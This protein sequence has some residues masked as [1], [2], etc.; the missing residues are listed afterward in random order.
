M[1]I[2]KFQEFL[3]TGAA[4]KTHLHFAN[5]PL[6]VQPQLNQKPKQSMVALPLVFSHMDFLL[7][8]VLSETG[9]GDFNVNIDKK[10]H[11]FVVCLNSHIS[12]RY[13]LSKK[14]SEIM[15]KAYHQIIADW[16]KWWLSNKHT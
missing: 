6:Q 15:Q 13:F 7:I 14:E 11:E 12:Q 10:N 5:T 1:T 8:Q 9:H 3:Q 4:I 16:S 2:S